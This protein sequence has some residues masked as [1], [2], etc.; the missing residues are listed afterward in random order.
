MAFTQAQSGK[1]TNN[2]GNKM[3]VSTKWLG[4]AKAGVLTAAMLAT[5]AAVAPAAQA[6]SQDVVEG[7]AT[8]P[9]ECPANSTCLYDQS[10]GLGP[11]ISVVLRWEGGHTLAPSGW[12]DRASAYH[13]THTSIVRY[14][15]DDDASGRNCMNIRA[16][17]APGAQGVLSGG[18][19]NTVDLVAN[20]EW[21]ICSWW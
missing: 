12:N 6:T 20:Q 13:D 7:I 21:P 14:L 8:I 17:V 9:F 5:A 3:R 16:V 11:Y 15:Y 1:F 2:G 10:D 18:N 4:A 19:D